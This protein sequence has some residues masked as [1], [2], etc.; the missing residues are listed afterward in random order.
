M[1]SGTTVVRRRSSDDH[2]RDGKAAAKRRQHEELERQLRAAGYNVQYHVRALGHREVLNKRALARA[3]AL[4][5]TSP[6]MTLRKLH[7]ITVECLGAVVTT[8]RVLERRRGAEDML[9]PAPAPDDQ[10]VAAWSS[11]A[12]PG[13]AG[14]A[15]RA[16]ASGRRKSSEKARC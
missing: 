12:W 6:H 16:P 1:D 9:V 8:R 14:V 2:D 7:E 13:V 5:A 11:S 10:A 3:A 15:P 4:K